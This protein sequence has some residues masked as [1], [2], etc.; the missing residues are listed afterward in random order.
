LQL[1]RVTS[2]LESA[3]LR[4]SSLSLMPTNVQAEARKPLVELARE[5]HCLPVV[6]VLNLPER[7]VS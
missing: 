4:G 5:F 1:S 6:I 2:L 7:V 3:W